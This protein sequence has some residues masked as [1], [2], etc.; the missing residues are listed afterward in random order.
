MFKMTDMTEKSGE[1]VDGYLT[2]IEDYQKTAVAMVMNAN[3]DED[4]LRRLVG[5]V[6]GTEVIL[7]GGSAEQAA[8]VGGLFKTL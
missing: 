8:D 6:V 5:F 7:R 3:N 4:L 2:G 1:F